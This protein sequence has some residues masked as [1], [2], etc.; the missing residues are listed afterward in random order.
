MADLYSVITGI[1]PDQQDIVEAELF[2]RQ[3]LEAK[4]PDLDLREG[5]A[6]RDLVLR[7]SALL[8]AICKKGFNGC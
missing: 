4:F 3:I 1:Q 7:P 5:T 6:I 8:L 2:A